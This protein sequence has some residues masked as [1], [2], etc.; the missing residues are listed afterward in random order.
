VKLRPASA[1]VA[2]SKR[3]RDE[4]E[5]NGISA[6]DQEILDRA[7]EGAEGEKLISNPSLWEEY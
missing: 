6:M 7:W 2:G 1:A 5:E 4:D 3:R